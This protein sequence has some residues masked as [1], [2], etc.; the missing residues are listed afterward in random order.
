MAENLATD[1]SK[2]IGAEDVAELARVMPTRRFNNPS[3]AWKVSL[4]EGLEGVDVAH[5]TGADETV[6]EAAEELLE[7]AA[8]WGMMEMW[9]GVK[10]MWWFVGEMLG[11][12]GY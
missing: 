2:C 4:F 11:D 9:Q 7:E 5:Q 8:R 1:V 6:L 12:D 3:K 10:G